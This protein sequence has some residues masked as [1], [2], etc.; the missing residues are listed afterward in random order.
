MQLR[1][2]VHQLHDIVHSMV[3]CQR[4]RDSKLLVVYSCMSIVHACVT[5]V[6]EEVLKARATL[7]TAPTA[8]AAA[9]TAATHTAAD[10]S[11]V[12]NFSNDSSNSISNSNDNHNDG[13]I[14]GNDSWFESWHSQGWNSVVQRDLQRA[15]VDPFHG[16]RAVACSCYTH[17]LDSDWS[18]MAQ[19]T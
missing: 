10:S 14:C 17:L 18:D 13:S 19:V 4:M 3:P 16:V 1:L 6:L 15:L 7:R 9:A 2:G 5:Q 11:G 8:A 12:H